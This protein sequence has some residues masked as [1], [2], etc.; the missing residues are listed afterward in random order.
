[1]RLFAL[2]GWAV[3]CKIVFSLTDTSFPEHLWPRCEQRTLTLKLKNT[4]KSGVLW[5]KEDKRPW[6]ELNQTTCY[7]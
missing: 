2:L 1:M 6:Q 4:D 5:C 7:T 3:S